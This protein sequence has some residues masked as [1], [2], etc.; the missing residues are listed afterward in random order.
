MYSKTY[1]FNA[2]TLGTLYIT[3]LEA[4]CLEKHFCSDLL[5]KYFAKNHIPCDF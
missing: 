2:G 3:A 4:L 5:N 1:I